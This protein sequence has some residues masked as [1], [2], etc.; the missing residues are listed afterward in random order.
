[1]LSDD[2]YRY[3]VEHI[4]F[5]PEDNINNPNNFLGDYYRYIA[6]YQNEEGKKAASDKAYDA[7]KEAMEIARS[8]LLVTH[9]IRLGI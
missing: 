8:D 4:Y 6:E 9:P 7:Y 5:Q 3:N 2:Y 1:M